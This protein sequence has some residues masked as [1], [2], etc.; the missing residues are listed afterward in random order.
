MLIESLLVP[1]MGTGNGEMPSE[2]AARQM[3][4]AYDA[5]FSGRGSGQGLDLAVF[6]QALPQF[7]VGFLR[8]GA[9]LDLQ[10]AAIELWSDGRRQVLDGPGA[11][12]IG[13]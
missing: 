9:V 7:G 8:H 4:T 3:R 6:E 5:I 13:G 11:V 1:G 2:R 12:H 10:L